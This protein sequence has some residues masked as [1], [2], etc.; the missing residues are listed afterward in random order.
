MSTVFAERF[1]VL[2]AAAA[3]AELLIEMT[4]STLPPEVVT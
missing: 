1:G 4:S 2:V 3:L